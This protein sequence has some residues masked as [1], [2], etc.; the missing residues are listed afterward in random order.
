MNRLVLVMAWVTLGGTV[1]GEDWPGFRGPTGQGHTSA[2]GL[3]LR[4]STTEN[5]RWK[6]PIPGEG[7]SSPIVHGDRV[8]I[9]CATEKGTVCRVLCLDRKTGS[10]LWNRELFKQVPIRSREKN[11]PATPTPVTDGE[12]VYAVFGDGSVAALKMTGEVAWTNREI[13]FTSVHG[14]GASPILYGDLLIMPYDG[15]SGGSDKTVG[16][17][18]PWDQAIILALDK[19]TGKEKWRASRGLSRIGHVSPL[20]I[21]AGQQDMLI[22]NAGDV[23]QGFDP[24]TGKRLW[25]LRSEGEGVVPTPVHAE[26]LLFCISGFGKPTLRA[27][28]PGSSDGETPPTIAWELNK[29]VPMIPS[30]VYVK[31]YVFAIS[32][33]GFAICLEASTGKVQWQQRVGG[34][35]SAS[36][37]ATADGKIYLLSEEGETTILEAKP[38]YKELAR[39]KLEE[40]TQASMAVAGKDL[41]IRTQNNL[42]CIGATR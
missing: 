34:T 38:I 22:S 20:I 6:R 39:N 10:V 12:H 3:P 14:L 33:K 11:S 25:S 15:S 1:W 32:E 30:V 27:V 7:W 42:Y 19:H 23:I 16:W 41:F 5:V 4:W 31:P 21:R 28:R 40:R 17:Q 2:S 26:G 29:N 36:P 24:K 9:T 13:K 18:K 37:V 35:F 8:F